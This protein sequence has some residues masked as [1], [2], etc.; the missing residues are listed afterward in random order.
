MQQEQTYQHNI[1]EHAQIQTQKQHWVSSIT[2]YSCI[3]SLHQMFLE[4]YWCR[5][6]IFGSGKN[7]ITYI[8]PGYD[9]DFYDIEF[10]ENKFIVR[11]PILGSTYQYKL[12]FYDIIDACDYVKKQFYLYQYSKL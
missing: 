7:H 4:H 11:I 3:E 2:V 1:H 10:C 5:S 6:N 9:L 8:K 12:V